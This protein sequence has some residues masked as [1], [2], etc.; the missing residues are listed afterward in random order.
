[1][2]DS[3]NVT[4]T[5][6]MHRSYTF[7][8]LTGVYMALNAVRDAYLLMDAPN[9]SYKKISSIDKNHDWHSTIFRKNG[10]HRLAHTGVTSQDVIHERT[11]HIVDMLRHMSS[12]PEIGSLWLCSMPMASITGIQYDLIVSTAQKKSTIPIIEIPSKS[13]SHDWLSGYKYTLSSIAN[14]LE[15]DSSSKQK[16]HVS[17]IGYLYDRNEGD[18]KGNLELLTY[19]LKHLGVHV[20]TIWLNGSSYNDLSLVA[21]SEALIALPYAGNAA[22][23]IAQKT[24]AAVIETSLPIGLE[25]TTAWITTIAEYFNVQDKAKEFI[26]KQLELIIPA[27][28]WIIPKYCI[29]KTISYI[30]DPYLMDAVAG[31]CNEFGAHM[32]KAILYGK[33]ELSESLNFLNNTPEV[34]YESLDADFSNFSCDYIIGNSEGL[35]IKN[36]KHKPYIQLGYPS[37]GHHCLTKSPF[38]G[39]VG[40]INLLNRIMN[41]VN[42]AEI[43]QT[44]V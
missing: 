35:Y 23:K 39:Y 20:D 17:I 21:Q 44:E 37:Q 22:K 4:N 15:L 42:T 19:Y 27:M 18:H 26:E 41:E 8:Y 12:Y 5:E 2:D 30:G 34:Y 40:V 28:K 3:E 33:N 9:C 29:S 7:S 43:K 25:L 24:G 10:R 16:N 38:M 11:G 36:A 14:A 1:M 32:D 31:V 6:T 13:L